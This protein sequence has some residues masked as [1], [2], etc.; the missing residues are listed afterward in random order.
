MSLNNYLSTFLRGI[1][2]TAFFCTFLTLSLP[3]IGQTIALTSSGEPCVGTSMSFM[4]PSSQYCA[5]TWSVEGSN[6]TILGQSNYSIQV[7]WNTPQSMA[8]VSVYYAD[9]SSPS[10][11]KGFAR[12]SN[13]TIVN[14]VTPSVS[15]SASTTTIC[16]NSQVSFTATPTNGGPSPTYIWRVNGASIASGSTNT[17]STTTLLAGTNTVSCEMVSS[18]TCLTSSSVSATSTITVNPRPI[19]GI[20]NASSASICLGNSITITGSGGTGVLYYS[21][22]SN[23]GTSWNVFADSYVGQSSFNYTPTQTG[24][25]RFHLRNKTLCGFCWEVGN[26]QCPTYPYVDVVVNAYPTA[27]ITPGGPFIIN[28]NGSVTLNANTSAGYQYQWQLNGNPIL[29]A[30]AA[31]YAASQAGSYTVVVTQNGCSSTSNSVAVTSTCLSPPVIVTATPGVGS[32]LSTKLTAS[33]QSLAFDGIDDYINIPNFSINGDPVTIEFWTKLAT[34][35]VQ[36]SSLFAAGNND[37]QRMCALL[38]SDKRLYWDY[39]D[40][41][42]SNG[43]MSVDFA[44]YLD[45]WTHV[46]LVSSGVGGNFRAIYLNGVAVAV[47]NTSSAPNVLLTG[48]KIGS[49]SNGTSPFKGSLDEFRIWYKVRSQTEIQ[50]N[51]NLSLSAKAPN[52]AGYWKLDEGL[53]TLTIDATGKGDNGTLTNG[54]SWSATASTYNWTPATKLSATSGAVVYATPLSNTNY[55]TTATFANGCTSLAQAMVL[56]NDYN[57]VITNDIQKTGITTDAQL[58]GLIIDKDQ[59]NQSITYLDGLSKSIQSIYTQASPTKQDLVEFTNYDAAGRQVRQYLPYSAGNDGG[60]KTD[61]L[62]VQPTFYQ[63]LKGDNTAFSESRFDNSPLNRIIEQ[64]SPGTTWQLANTA[65]EGKTRKIAYSANE[66]NEIRYWNFNTTSKTATG[67]AFY[68]ANSLS[69]ARSIDEH[70]YR[71][72]EYKDK[73]GR[74]VARRVQKL[75]P[76]LVA[77]YSF[78]GNAND[79][80]LNGNHGTV[81]GA[82]LTADRFAVANS[83]YQFNGSS[84]TISIPATNLQL[85]NYTY[86]IWVKPA[87]SPASGSATSILSIGSAGADQFI[88]LGNAYNSNTGWIGGGYHIGGTNSLY[89]NGSLPTVNTWSHLTLTRDNSN[90]KLYINGV[91]SGSVSTNGNKPDYGANSGIVAAMLGARTNLIQFFQGALDDIRI[92]N[93]ALSATE[94]TDLYT[95]NASTTSLTSDLLTYYIYDD[96]GNIRFTV[97][98]EA[99]NNLPS[100]GYSLT[101]NNTFCQKWLFAY[102]YDARFRVTEKLTPG[103]GVS[104]LVY[105]PADRVILTQDAAHRGSNQW[106][107]TKY[108]VLARTIMT[109]RYTYTAANQAAMQQAVDNYYTLNPTRTYYETRKNADF[110]NL[111]GYNNQ[112]FPVLPSPNS[113]TGQPYVV[114]YYDDYDFDYNGTA[115]ETTKGEPAFVAMVGFAA[116]PASTK[117]KP[118]GKRV[119]VLGTSTW[120]TS[121]VYYDPQGRVIQTQDE[122]YNNATI[123]SNKGRNMEVI[124][125]LYE[126]ITERIN[127]TERWH[128][129]ALVDQS[130]LTNMTLKQSFKYDAASRLTESTMQVGSG[131]PERLAAYSYNEAG[132]LIKKIVGN[133]NGLQTVDYQYNIRGWLKAINGGVLTGSDLFAMSFGHE[134]ATNTNPQ[135]NGNLS[136]MAWISKTDLKQRTY[137]YGYDGLNRLLTANYT[138]AVVAERFSVFTTY[139]DD[140]GNIKTLNRQNLVSR[141]V[142]DID[143]FGEVDKLQYE[144]DGNRLKTVE[145]DPNLPADAPANDFKEKSQKANYP[146][147]YSY[148]QSGKLLADK[149]KGLN[150]AFIYNDLD[151]PEV[152]QMS[153]TDNIANTYAA[154]GDKLQ[155]TVT[156]SSNVIGIYKYI[157]DIIYL[158]DVPQFISTPEG[159]ILS[160]QVSGT[161]SWVYEYFYLDHLGDLRMAFRATPAVTINPATMDE[162]PVS[163]EWSN[164]SGSIRNAEEKAAGLN[165]AKLT[166]ANPIGPWKTIKVNKGDLV[167][168]SAQGLYRLQPANNNAVNLTTYVNSG[169]PEP[170][171]ESKSRRTWLSIGIAANFAAINTESNSIPKAY[172][173]YILE[174]S[175]ENNS[176]DNTNKQVVVRKRKYLTSAAGIWESLSMT[177]SVEEEGYLQVLVVNESDKPVW[178]D[179]VDIDVNPTLTYQETH[180]DPW[181]LELTGIGEVGNPEHRYKF[182]G[183]ESIT[184]LSLFWQDFGARFYDAQLGRWHVGDPANQFASPYL[185]MGNTPVNGTD[186]DGRLF[187]IDDVTAIVIGAVVNLGMNIAQGNFSSNPL[188]AIGQGLGYA[189]AGA[190]AGE[191]ATL[192]PAG[193]AASGALLGASNAAI[194]GQ[195]LEA[196]IQQGMVGTL[197][198]LVGGVVGARALSGFTATINGITSPIINGLVKGAVGG[199]AGGFAGGT[200]ATLATGGTFEQALSSGANGFISGMFIGSFTGAAAAGSKAYNDGLNPFSG[201]LRPSDFTASNFRSNLM[202]EA[203]GT[204]FDDAHHVFP[205]RFEAFFR[206]AQIDIHNPRYGTFWEYTNHRANAYY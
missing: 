142:N 181:G 42:T 116:T 12:S 198:G 167:T 114:N 94:V 133:G 90:I 7:Q 16:E 174:R 170:T 185:G 200:V 159:R 51:M 150:T 98:P 183:K 182:Q 17:Y 111:H 176:N 79:N 178:F 53:G 21:C 119:L 1:L 152:I 93:R 173:E 206:Q 138:S 161:G 45:K 192:G 136:R 125:T 201:K 58:Q 84:S 195:G 186:P 68:P 50:A 109:G 33:T 72:W 122:N 100:V 6:Y 154:N 188:K 3:A 171:T 156:K 99:V 39:G 113:S 36:N 81:N 177:Y 87:S 57:Y 112:A 43:R 9:C 97:P 184:D 76:G 104:W 78:S 47:M 40:W 108:D 22:S 92:Y 164:T 13:Y 168:I 31:T 77:S 202:Q 191:L 149:N 26:N 82:T 124:S 54:P 24:T 91:L 135:F 18:A 158:D 196:S 89:K 129:Y 4:L 165:S 123:V 2:F 172:I 83:A 80:S 194:S 120:L 175:D 46:A 139:N 143:N 28:V 59:L 95:S 163:A 61:A 67:T 126:G 190:A 153:S 103:G 180:Y 14:K 140:N 34:T 144:Y 130:S 19:D 48:L 189:L 205:Q 166:T 75:N 162:T 132:E 27:S 20:I 38:W 141:N 23:G 127:K 105:D 128:C 11:I 121:A 25:Y 137:Q 134:E 37:P 160:P 10:T 96:F 56:G 41:N 71:S 102:D 155:M 118:T 147:E 131:T 101:Y 169:M 145:D 204:S 179:N 157:G 199:A 146:T 197:S 88:L 63:N 32:N 65:A 86:S 73:A 60:Y 107:F 64:S 35:D 8:S 148:D 44:P 151:L 29:N 62:A 110:S 117:G 106:M 70:G 85:S 187:G 66:E 203:W 74:T 115:A 30:T 55:S 193:W 15:L 5:V 69:V 52:L 49:F